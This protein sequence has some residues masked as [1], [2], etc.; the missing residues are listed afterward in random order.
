MTGKLSAGLFILWKIDG[1][2]HGAIAETS[3]NAV[4]ASV[5]ANLRLVTQLLEVQT[6]PRRIT[7]GYAEHLAILD[8]P[9]YRAVGLGESET[10]A[11]QR[12]SLM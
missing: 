11:T 9:W 8:A 2:L 6:V 5:I 10:T 12:R 3:G 1:I 4:M 7:P